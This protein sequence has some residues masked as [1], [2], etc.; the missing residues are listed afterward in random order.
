MLHM[1]FRHLSVGEYITSALNQ[2]IV[3]L[4][5]TMYSATSESLPHKITTETHLKNGS[6]TLIILLVRSGCMFFRVFRAL[7]CFLARAPCDSL[8]QLIAR[9][10]HHSQELQAVWVTPSST[11]P[12]LTSL[13]PWPVSCQYYHTGSRVCQSGTSTSTTV[14]TPAGSA[15]SAQRKC[16]PTCGSQRAT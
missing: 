6:Y 5:N 16:T 4:M 13:G 10:A 11:I 14:G 9:I 15:L 8:W 2:A 7:L 3:N 12:A 1:S